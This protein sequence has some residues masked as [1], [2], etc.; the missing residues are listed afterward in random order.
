M[1]A[2]LMVHLEH[3]REQ[4]R[5][6]GCPSGG[7]PE[8]VLM[9]L[10]IRHSGSVEDDRRDL[11]EGWR[12]FY[13]RLQRRGWTAPYC[14][15]WEATSGRD[16]LGHVHLHVAIIWPRIP[17]S[18][19]SRLW[20]ASC[21]RSEVID[22]KGPRKDRKP[23][24]AWTAA[25]YLSKYISKGIDFDALPAELAADIVAASYNQKS[26]VHGTGRWAPDAATGKMQRV[27]FFQPW[28]RP[29]CD[30]CGVLPWPDVAFRPRTDEEQADVDR[31]CRWALIGLLSDRYGPA[32][33]GWLSSSVNLS[34]LSGMVELARPDDPAE[35]GWKHGVRIPLGWSRWMERVDMDRRAAGY[36]PQGSLAIS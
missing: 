32:A 29:H 3:E 7:R 33:A 35:L 34:R 31:G 4:W 28:E 10:T 20:R 23:T 5:R 24:N 1:A 19:V 21:P 36:E 26:V 22:L 8:I 30:C 6:R 18:T 13:R 11:A 2:G 15:A 12:E 17:W 16:G 9:T 25:K 14:G 27:K